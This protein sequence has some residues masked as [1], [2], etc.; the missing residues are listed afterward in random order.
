MASHGRER[1]FSCQQNPFVL[2]RLLTEYV[3][4]TDRRITFD[5]EVC[6]ST[7]FGDS[8]GRLSSF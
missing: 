6:C 1:I 2:V 4:S 8:V 5:P 7:V 3:L